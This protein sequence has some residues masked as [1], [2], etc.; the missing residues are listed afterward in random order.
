MKL[1]RAIITLMRLNKPVGIYLLWF[2]TA[3]ALSLAYPHHPPFDIYILFMLGTL[4]MRSAGCVINDIA[5]RKWD[6]FVTRTQDRPL[7]NQSISLQAAIFCFCILIFFAIVILLQL[8]KNC[9]YGAIPAILLTIIYP[10]CK[11]FFVTPQLI[12]GF[13]FASSI[14][15]V[16]LASHSNWTIS[17]SLLLLITICWVLVYDTQYAL[18]DLQDDK[19]VGI[20]STARFFE[21]NIYWF[22]NGL[23]L[24][25]HSLWLVFA[26]INHK[27]LLFYLGWVLGIGFGVCQ[28]L[29]LKHHQP[30]KAFKNNVWY[31]LW[32]WLILIFA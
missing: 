23:Q 13:A 21:K 17:W 18:V 16:A 2:P 15:M 25:T 3:W 26:S 27:S 9:F 29:V 31:G 32:M 24:F 5:D 12:L 30:F 1:L 4:V 11:R 28:F 20:L 14:P 22:I 19:R 7:A 6:K 10:F 8:P